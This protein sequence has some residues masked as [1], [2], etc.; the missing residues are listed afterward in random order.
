MKKFMKLSALFLLSAISFVSCDTE[1]VDPVLLETIGEQPGT[2]GLAVFKVDFS[3]ATHTAVASTA[4]Y[5]EGVLNIGAVLNANGEA[6]S[7]SIDDTAVKTY[8]ESF[9]GYFPG[10][11]SA[12]GYLNIDPATGNNQGSVTITKFDAVN[13]TISG[14][15]N[16][17]GW[18][19]DATM[20]LPSIA[21]TNGIFENIPVIG[22]PD[23]P[24]T[25]PVNEKFFKA[26]V[27]GTAKTFG[28]IMTFGEGNTWTISATNT[29]SQ[30][31]MSITIPETIT[32]G[33]YP[34]EVFTKY[35]ASYISLT[36]DGF[37]SDSG[38]LTITS[39]S[40][41]WIKG[42]FSFS[43]EDIDGNLKT[44]TEGQFS[45]QD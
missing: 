14:R 34:L 5:Q 41:G 40:N 13:K 3:N 20:N 8:T 22:L 30:E 43:G 26:K 37:S 33:T 25:N 2:V 16:F 4:N 18:Y 6:L 28:T 39:H 45:L 42:T 7:I 29:A 15:F 38:T 10:N 23:N 9:I 35:F 24:G 44:V 11:S 31:S 27:N 19:G 36:G 32:P 21:F 17:T 1:A 12:I